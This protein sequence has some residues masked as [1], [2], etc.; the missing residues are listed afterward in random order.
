MSVIKSANNKS[1]YMHK[2]GISLFACH[3]IQLILWYQGNA[4]H[5]LLTS[6][7]FETLWRFIFTS[8]VRLYGIAQG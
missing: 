3:P 4:D 6:T 2:E 8:R 7:E 1:G 5:S